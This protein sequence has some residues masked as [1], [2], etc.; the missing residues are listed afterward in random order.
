MSSGKGLSILILDDDV[1]FLESFKEFLAQDGHLVYPATR[2]CQAL[3]IVRHVPLDL[4]F[5]DYDLPDLDGI[6]TFARIHRQRPELPAIFLSG[7][8][9]AA[10]ERMVLEVGGFALI[11]KPFDACRLRVVIRE[12]ILKN[13]FEGLE[14]DVQWRN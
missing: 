14:G 13:P 5:L 3:E 10:L 11:R 2:G 9:S 4:S 12:A 1:L 6:E 7:N 8:S